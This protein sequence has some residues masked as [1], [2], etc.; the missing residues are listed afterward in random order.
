[1]TKQEQIQQAVDTAIASVPFQYRQ[2]D[3]KTTK[4]ALR[5]IEELGLTE[6][7]PVNMREHG[8]KYA[9]SVAAVIRAATFAGSSKIAGSMGE[10]GS[11]WV[12]TD[13]AH[14]LYNLLNMHEEEG[15]VIVSAFSGRQI[16]ISQETIDYIAKEGHLSTANYREGIVNNTLVDMPVT[17]VTVGPNVNSNQ[18]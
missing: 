13:K 2:R 4:K 15:K 9:S 11:S 10:D 18:I 17:R 14:E 8:G 1:M 12:E 16:P 5:E 7:L 6:Y 3:T